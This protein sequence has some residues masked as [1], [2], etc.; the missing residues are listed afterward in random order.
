[1]PPPISFPSFYTFPSITASGLL[2]INF[3]FNLFQ[4]INLVEPLVGMISLK[5]DSTFIFIDFCTIAAML[6]YRQTS[7]K[8]AVS[9]FSPFSSPIM[10]LTGLGQG[11]LPSI[12]LPSPP[13]G[14][15][16]SIGP[17]HLPSIMDLTGFSKDALSSICLP[18]SPM[19]AAGAIGP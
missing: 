17:W 3:L 2:S 7:T 18:S 5:V 19:G 13:I 8:I 6:F 15:M 9:P 10:D 16:G 11:A 12:C 14:P 4:T 1:M